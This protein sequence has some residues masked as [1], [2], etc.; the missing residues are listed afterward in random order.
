MRLL[1]EAMQIKRGHDRME[2]LEHSKEC[3]EP[4]K[5]TEKEQP[6]RYKRNEQ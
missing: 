6:V 5:E 3:L 1:R 4:A 2:Y